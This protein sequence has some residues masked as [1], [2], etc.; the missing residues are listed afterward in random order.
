MVSAGWYD[1]ARGWPFRCLGLRKR[2]EEPSSLGALVEG[3]SANVASNSRLWNAKVWG[4]SEL[5]MLMVGEAQS[6]AKVL[7]D[8][9]AAK[10]GE[11]LLFSASFPALSAERLKRLAVLKDHLGRAT[12]EDSTLSLR[13]PPCCRCGSPPLG[14]FRRIGCSVAASSAPT[15]SHMAERVI[16]E[17]HE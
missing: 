4:L 16:P 6:S 11:D 17:C 1:L 5:A 13:A 8:V 9:L 10:A 2:S 15:S 12:A 3:Q 7:I 14:A